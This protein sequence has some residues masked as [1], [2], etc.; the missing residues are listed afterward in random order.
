MKLHTA[1]PSARQHGTSVEEAGGWAVGDEVRVRG[2]RGLFRI[3]ELV[4]VDGELAWVTAWGPISR[5]PSKPAQDASWRS[6]TP[7]RLRASRKGS[8]R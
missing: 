6:F 4:V 5:D 7:D 1:P 8:R 2:E 3:L